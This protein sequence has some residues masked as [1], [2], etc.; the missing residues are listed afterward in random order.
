M[1]DIL[2]IAHYTQVPI[3][4]GK[5]RFHYL[6]TKIAKQT[7]TIEVVTTSFSHMNKEQRVVTQEQ[8]EDSPYDFTMLYEP[9][10]AKNISLKRFYSHYILGRNLGTYLNER[11]VP[12]V[13]YCA[14]PS[15]EA[16]F[17]AAKYAQKNNV[18]FII[19]VQDLWPEA[20]RMI[21]NVPL[22]SDLVFYPFKKQADY[23]YQAADEIVAV[24]QTYLDRALRD[25]HTK[26]K[27]SI[28]LGVD[29]GL[30]DELA[31]EHLFKDKP[32]DEIWVVYIGTLGHSYDLKSVIDALKILKDEG[33]TNIKFV[34]M[35]SGPL[36]V[37]FEDYAK[38]KEI[39]AVFTGQL[40]YEKMIGVLAASDIAVNPIK[41]DSAGSIINKVADYAAAGLPVINTQESIE[42]RK[43]LTSYNAGVNVVNGDTE[44]L[45]KKIKQL[46]EDKDLRK[47]MGENNR[48]LAEKK[49]DRKNT[50]NEIVELIMDV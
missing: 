4:N 13:I 46:V 18:R 38:E 8:L 9:N 2:V 26:S 28:Y 32:K 15:L 34:V 16:G 17:V 24:S 12:D 44:D 42:Y 29:L 45:S 27:H 39:H 25:N 33:M 22:I 6:A 19:D 43:L 23:I 36:E 31:A 35:G 30:F 7:D 41:K 5:G 1:R 10:Y 14:V 40:D 37:K 11:K 50:Y 21:F 49:F 47:K 48:L 3:E 20:F